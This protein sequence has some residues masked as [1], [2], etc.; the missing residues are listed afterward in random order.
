MRTFFDDD[1]FPESGNRL[2][3]KSNPSHQ[4]KNIK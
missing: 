3:M 2:K 4:N 1:V